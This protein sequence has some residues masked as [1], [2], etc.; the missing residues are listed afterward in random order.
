MSLKKKILISEYYAEVPK[1]PSSSSID[2]GQ[3]SQPSM[4]PQI[5][6]KSKVIALRLTTMNL[7]QVLCML[8]QKWFS[9]FKWIISIE[10]E[11]TPDQHYHI[12]I[13]PESST[14][15]DVSFNKDIKFWRKLL[16]EEVFP[17]L[18]IK[19]PSGNKGY[20]LT[21]NETDNIFPYTLKDGQFWY[22]IYT[23]EQ[24][25]QWTKASYRKYTKND[26]TVDLEK[27]RVEFM[28][29]DMCINDAIMKYIQLKLQY[30]Q[31]ININNIST[32]M[33]G[34]FYAKNPKDVRDL[35]GYITETQIKPMCFNMTDRR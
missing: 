31:T 28:T 7:P 5:V 25:D 21:W 1:E 30:K 12:I 10:K 33:R 13:D 17:E 16:V 35:A 8:F 22:N 34:W 3:G 11:N 23:K 4:T 29:T 14:S 27:I 2:V 15:A 24:I 6:Q 19:I 9:N 32:F 20:S 26:F 18:P